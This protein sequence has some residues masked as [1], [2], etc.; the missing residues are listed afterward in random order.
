MENQYADF[1]IKKDKIQAI[2]RTQKKDILF[3]LNTL[4]DI[5]YDILEKQDIDFVDYEVF[6][7]TL[8]FDKLQKFTLISDL[9]FNT[10]LIWYKNKLNK[11]KLN[12]KET[13]LKYTKIKSVCYSPVSDTIMFFIND[14]IIADFLLDEFELVLKDFSYSNSKIIIDKIFKVFLNFICLIWYFTSKFINYL[15]LIIIF[16]ISKLFK[17]ID[18]RN[19]NKIK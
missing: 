17:F 14:S 11:Q 7:H 19:K 15:L 2:K 10:Y 9:S 16:F 1:L 8:E 4:I 18:S 13:I 5:T 3:L 12:P 6:K